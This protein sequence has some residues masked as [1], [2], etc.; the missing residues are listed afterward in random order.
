LRIRDFLR[1]SVLVKVGNQ[2]P[3]RLYKDGTYADRS[4]IIQNKLH[5]DYWHTGNGLRLEATTITWPL[6]H[7]RAEKE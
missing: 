6:P 7:A 3:R 4:D 2:S 1:Q 5:G